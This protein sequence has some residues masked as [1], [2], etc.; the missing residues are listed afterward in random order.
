MSITHNA[1]HNNYLF[2]PNTLTN[3]IQTDVK[4]KEGKIQLI[5]RVK[6]QEEVLCPYCGSFVQINNHHTIKLKHLS[7][8]QVPV[9]INV[10]RKQYICPSCHRTHQDSLPFKA[11][12]HFITKSLQQF[13]EDLLSLHTLSIT[14][15]SKLTHTHSSIIKEIDKQR[16]KQQYHSGK[17]KLG[18]VICCYKKP[19]HYSKLLGIDE[20]SLHKHHCYAT[21]IMDLETGEVLYVAYGKTKQTV[22][23]FI[24]IFGDRFMK[25]VEAIACDMNAGYQAAF[26]EKY[27]HLEVVYDYFHIVKN[28]NDNVIT[29]V[30]NDEYQRLLDEHKTA[31]AKLLKS[32]R[33]L[34]L[35]NP[36]KLST[37]KE[38]KLEHIFSTN[39]LLYTAEVIKETIDY[40][41][42]LENLTE[43]ETA[44]SVVVNLCLETQ[45]QYFLWFARLIQNH[46][47]GIIM[48]AKYRISTGKVKGT[49]NK[50]KTT[51]RLAYGYRDDEYFFLKILDTTN[52]SHR[53]V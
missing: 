15:I 18:K 14:T 35:A 13:I 28:F 9:S 44:M 50:I 40:A 5:G 20:F 36:G 39:K 30:R 37:E 27:P 2:L 42:S 33:Y 12:H 1:S 11:P 38:I 47:D 26:K 51:K 43:M 6:P 25:Q 17:N 32:A 4:E 7:L 22:Y 21:V 10:E 52:K 31:E 46:L 19:T 8:G 29:K 23:N 48:H 45:N 53:K 49:N 24:K 16:L 3:F 34:L 41:Y